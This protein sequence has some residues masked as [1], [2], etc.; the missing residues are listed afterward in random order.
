MKLIKQKVELLPQNYELPQSELLN[1][2]YKQIE[3]I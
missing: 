2:I 3:F 1:N